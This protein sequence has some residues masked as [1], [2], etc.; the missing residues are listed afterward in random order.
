[1]FAFIEKLGEKPE[2]YFSRMAKENIFWE[3]NVSFDSVHH[4]R[5]HQYMLNFFEDKEKQ[6][7]VRESGVRLS[8]GFDGHRIAEY[9]PDRVKEYCKKVHDAGI[10]LVFE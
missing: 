9:R 3:M 7:I 1:M 4:Y 10:K 5:E 8:V 6:Q 2:E